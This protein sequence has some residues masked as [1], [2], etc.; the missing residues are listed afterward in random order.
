M[1]GNSRKEILDRAFDSLTKGGEQRLLTA[2]ELLLLL[3]S[4]YFSIISSNVSWK[5]NS[6]VR[7]YSSFSPPRI[8]KAIERGEEYSQIGRVALKEIVQK[9]DGA[10]IRVIAG[11]RIM[12]AIIV[13]M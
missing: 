5:S 7:L 9:L 3:A 11:E 2:T 10:N 8:K 1:Y 12:T 6:F 4:N 13:N